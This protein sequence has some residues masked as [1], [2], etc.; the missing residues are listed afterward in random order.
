[1]SVSTPGDVS[2]ETLAEEF[3]DRR[4]RGERPTLNEYVARY[5]LLAAEILEFFPVLGLVE[6]FK[7]GTGET[8][9]SIAGSLIPGLAVAPER[10][11]DF[12]LLREVGRG[13]MGIV[14]EAEQESLGRRVAL[15]VLRTH[16]LL[17]PKVV[18]RFHREAKAA[19]RLH[20]TNIVPVFGVGEH[21][22]AHFYVMQFIQG[23]ALDAVLAEIRRIA[24]TGTQTGAPSAPDRL[25]ASE[26]HRGDTTVADLVHSLATGRF[27]TAQLTEPGSSTLSC[28][29]ADHDEET[30]ITLAGQTGFSTATDSS[31]QYAHSVA[32]VGLQVAEALDYAHQ[33]GILHRDIKPSN[34]LLDAHGMVWVT[35]FGLAKVASDGDLTCTGDIVG[36]VRYMAPE[37]FEGRCD[38]RADVYALG[39]TLYELLARQPA[40]D[41]LDRASLIRQVTQEGPKALR[42]LDPAIPRDL[43][44]IVHTAIARD[45]ADRYASA[46]ELRDELDRFLSDRPIRSRPISP[47]EHYWR[48]CKRNPGLAVAS[49]IACVMTIA[50]AILATAA[51][52]HNGRLATQ[53]KDQRD[54]ARQNLIQAYTSE[55]DARRHSRR[56][57]QRFD[58]LDAI[59]RA[60]RLAASVGIGEPER[61][62]LR[63]QAIAAMGLPDMRVAWQVESPDS[64]TDGFAIDPDFK[65]YVSVSDEGIV[66]L[67][68]IADERAI[69][70]L[71]S[72][73]HHP[74]G[75]TGLFSPDGRYLALQ[76]KT[77]RGLLEVWDLKT[78]RLTIRDPDVSISNAAS[79]VFHPSQSQIAVGRNDGSIVFLELESG[80][81]LRRFSIEVGRPGAIAINCDATKLAVA[82]VISGMVTII[83]IDSGRIVNEL[84]NPDHVFHLAWNPRKPDVLAMGVEDHTVRVWDVLTSRVLNVFEGENYGGMIVA[85]HPGGDLLAS[86]GWHGVLRLW[87]TRTN[88]Q[89]LS[90][91]SAWRDQLYFGNAG[92]RLSPHGTA[93]RVGSLEVSYETECRTLLREPTSTLTDIGTLAIDRAGKLLAAANTQGIALWDVTTGTQLGLLPRVLRG[94]QVHFEPAGACAPATR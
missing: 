82:R 31:R 42:Q 79:W 54:E 90:M 77:D 86:R 12:R 13:G 64:K 53:L 27:A 16:R 76:S 75:R 3:L 9:G 94:A 11:G 62:K 35:D 50:I 72:D 56:V 7:P 49:T 78:S 5:P 68:R 15:K 4:R 39:L 59:A 87:D 74:V 57:G 37:R 20:H 93:D 44:T 66:S 30:A 21:E 10:L 55:A 71:K 1:M 81:E 19:A 40:F 33:H 45:P 88:R 46:A 83:A 91:P 69:Q 52:A 89:I 84:S 92:A 2:I 18:L 43:H 23:L 58:A 70:T 63:N 47:P 60:M 26:T 22:G 48:W 14:Y 8:S 6:E 61:A 38:A 67:R 34:L 80:R 41:A 25:V 17:D 28:P 24:T 65:R 36:T 32:R 51:A 73:S 85:F 29:A